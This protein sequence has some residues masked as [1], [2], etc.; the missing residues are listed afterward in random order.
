M[1]ASN[2]EWSGSPTSFGY[3]WQRCS[4]GCSSIGGATSQTYALVAADVGNSVKV[5]V[6]AT[7]S[8]GAV[9]AD[10]SASATIAAA[11]AGAPLNADAPGISGNA[12]PGETLTTSSGSW[13]GSSNTYTYQWLRCSS[14]AGGCSEIG[15]ATGITYNVGSGDAGSTIRVRVTATN[16]SGSNTALSAATG[17][18]SSGQAPSNTSKPTISGTPIDNQTVTAD[19]G[20]WSG[21]T[22]ITFSYQWQQCDS[23]GGSCQP[24]NGR[25]DRTYEVRSTDTG[26]TLRVLVTAA[27]SAG[28]SSTLS[29]PVTVVGG[30]IKPQNTSSPTIS[31]NP[32][33]NQVLTANPGSWTGTAPIAYS[34]RWQRGN[35]QGNSWNNIDNATARTYRLI[36]SDV[37]RRIRVTVTATNSAGS[38]VRTS[39]ATIVIQAIAPLNTSLPVISGTAR[40]GS[41]LSTTP[42]GW[43][44]A[45][46]ITFY[47]QWARCNSAGQSCVP[48]PGATR[49]KYVLVAADVGHR[50]IVQVKA[51]SSGGAGYA[52]SR[53]SGVVAAGAPAPGGTATSVPISS[54]ALPNRLVVDQLKF[55][56]SRI[57]S[58]SEQLVARFHV[59]ETTT[60]RS[61][62]GALVYAVGVPFDRLTAAREVSTDST[63]WATIVFSIKPTF[64]LRRG[65]LVVVFVR[66]RKPGDSV[67]AGVSTRRLVSV[68]VG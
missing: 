58:R 59:R 4:P 14:S 35:A 22:P 36:D 27:N 48:I 43:S 32:V 44:S 11:S 17:P 13:S 10:S 50:L 37:G 62:S 15:S 52:N 28:S 41:T 49:A 60:K 8:E 56:P 12:K 45:A 67:L 40:Q 64:E 53:S 57:R 18:V 21:D 30:Q 46:L 39:P 1:A 7:N 20:S 63:G 26:H 65:N 38:D 24:L 16:G 29:D 66:A 51:Q 19:P 55:T 31:G 6:T 2:G 61:V 23:G 68:R 33:R 54:V 3:Q 42:G 25:T 9:S 5:V 34:Y 47:Y